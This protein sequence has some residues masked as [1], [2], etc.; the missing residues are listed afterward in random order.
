MGTAFS[1]RTAA[2]LDKVLKSE[3]FPN[4]GFFGKEDY[5]SL[6]DALPV[7]LRVPFVI[8]YWTGMRSGE[9]FQLK[10][11][12]I[13]LD[14]GWI[15]LD[16]GTTKNDKGR[17]IP[18]VKEVCEMLS[19]W[20][21]VSVIQCPT[22]PWVCHNQGERLLRIQKQIWDKYCESVGL[23]G[24]LFHDLRRT[25]VRNMVRAHIPEKVAMEI[26]GHKTRSVF[27]RYH[28]VCEEDLMEAVSLLEKG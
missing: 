9:I 7:H 17:L 14:E 22:C 12:Q 6:K 25:A 20:K 23:K 26:S 18:L 24:K 21:K 11:N 1:A 2:S 5:L 16:S 27:D 28:I 19:H 10:W 15:R 8:A 3:L 4:P 13:N